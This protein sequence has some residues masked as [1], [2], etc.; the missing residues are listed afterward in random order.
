MTV[1][2]T[3]GQLVKT[4]RRALDL[5]QQDLA[6]QVG[7]SV[8]TIRK[9][10]TDERRPSRELAERLA[11]CLH[12][13]PERQGAFIGLARRQADW[14]DD[15]DSPTNLPTPPTRLIGR[16][17][18]Q[19]AVRTELLRQDS[20]MLTLVGP[21]GIGKSRL[22][23]EVAAEV[24][25]LFPDGVHFVALAPLGDE[26]LLVPSIATA[27]GVRE[28]PGTPLG[29][30]LLDHL[31]TRR[32]LL[33]L[34]D[35]EHLPGAARL[36]AEMLSAGPQ[37]R[38]LATSRAPLHLRGERLFPVPPLRLADDGPA[39]TAETAARAAAVELFVERAHAVDPHFALTDANAADVAA[40]CAGV[41]GLPLAI[42][43]VAARITLL[44]PPAILSRLSDRLA[45]LT[46][47]PR[48]LPERQ[49]TLR[50]T[51]DWSYDLL[52][53]A[54]QRLFARLAVFT[55]G[56]TV[57]SAEQVAGLDGERPGAILH[58]LTGLADKNLVRQEVRGDGERYA[59][60]FDMIREYALERLAA[61]GEEDRIRAAHAR[62]FLDLAE[63]AYG[64]LG[65]AAQEQ[66]LSRLDA[67]HNNLRAALEWHVQSDDAEGG[68]RLVAALWKF[69]HIRSHHTEAGRW[70]TLALHLT[71]EHD[72]AVRAR[73]L[74]GA[75]WIAVDRGDHL[76]ARAC[77]GESLNLCR[78]LGDPRGIAEALHGVGVM[79]QASGSGR[80]ALTLFEESLELYRGLGDDEGI[81]WSLDHLGEGRL[82]LDDPAGA[83][84]LFE[85]AHTIFGRLGHAWGA[86]ITL[87]H[88]GLAGLVQGDHAA[89]EERFARALELF[90]ELGSTWGVSTAVAHLGRAALAA[91]DLQRARECFGR[92]LA[93]NRAEADRD[94]VVRSLAGLAGVAIV[95]H[96]LERA[97]GLFGAISAV[98]R[99]LMDPVERACQA[100][101]LAVVRRHLGDERVARAWARGAAGGLD[102]QHE[103]VGTG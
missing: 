5:T 71:G 77:F 66:W 26:A 99:V 13:A 82:A 40:I 88:L 61:S 92:C 18:E 56:C 39:L 28:V 45:L 90:G 67:E 7:Y 86:V 58:G 103:P 102:A 69:W 44:S 31:R 10:E 85:A 33:L 46:D 29:M 95:E 89:A 87:D 17:H 57:A 8:I 54:E 75:G 3:F 9:V 22:S 101:D 62:Y 42:E 19:A 97:A 27:L 41:D 70:T 63:I 4:R 24:R 1:D 25:P 38:V 55:G 60:F 30:A 72:P 43:L 74:Y 15:R 32:L 68:L 21:P 35:C 49:Q 83:E 73:V 2:A 34:D 16:G 36:V 48:D 94:G 64:Q 80:Q 76:L 78:R 52:D 100:R 11:K 14:V 23:V 12:I 96:D 37:L 81:A 20:R 84:A 79:L 51:I 91:G 98:S 50:R 6:S 53:P 47:G 59:V 93:L 65:G